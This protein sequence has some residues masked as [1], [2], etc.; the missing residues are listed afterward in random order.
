MPEPIPPSGSLSLSSDP[1]NVEQL[2]NSLESI[3]TKSCLDEMSAFH[4][5]CAI[6][7]VVNNCI[8]HAYM[9]KSGQP[10]EIT[11]ELGPDRVQVT[12][13][14]RGPAFSEPVGA[15]EGSLLGES[16]RGLQIINAWVSSLKF[17]RK[18]DWNI[19]LL[20]QRPQA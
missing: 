17:E 16:G 12:I 14:D 8:Q 5:R 18:N 20:E 2:L 9:N 3:L 1:K 10:I 13:S 4:L 19:C 15:T 6:V 7:E 11:Y